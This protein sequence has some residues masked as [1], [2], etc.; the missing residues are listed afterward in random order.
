MRR[1]RYLVLFAAGLGAGIAVG[2]SSDDDGAAVPVEDAGADS[3]ARGDATLDEDSGAEDA[4]PDALVARP[5][6]VSISPETAAPG[7]ALTLR[8]VVRGALPGAV[9]SIDGATAPR[10]E[11]PDAGDVEDAGAEEGADVLFVSVP[12]TLPLTGVLPVVVQNVPGDPRSSS[13]PLFLTV[14]PTD[15][16]LSV[17]DF[18]PDHGEAGDTILVLGRNFNGPLA[19][20]DGR[21]IVQ[22]VDAGLAPRSWGDLT[23]V[24]VTAFVVPAA[25]STGQVR[26][27]RLTGDGV[28]TGTFNVGSNLAQSATASASSEFSASWPVAQGHDGD[29]STSWFTRDNDCASLSFC[30]SVPFYVVAFDGPK[31]IGRI[32][33]RGNREFID[34][35]DFIAGRFEIL[36]PTSSPD[37]GEGPDGG[38]GRP[39]LWS[40][41]VRLQNP[42]RDIDVRIPPPVQGHAVRFVAEADESNTPGLAEL[43]VFED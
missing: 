11:E 34:D 19:L 38:S 43:E 14:G 4:G 2:C 29:L 26:V 7:Q 23:N 35:Y 33:L 22:S 24:E 21:V 27:E 1:W 12:D 13:E 40:R 17:I 8:L 39:V 15:G 5:T 36:G 10:A 28:R 42:R 20:T 3:G 37:A 16:G 18:H 6:L 32:A 31:R 25:W 30:T 9:V 41:H